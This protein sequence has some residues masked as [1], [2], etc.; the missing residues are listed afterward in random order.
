MKKPHPLLRELPLCL[1]LLAL[2]GVLYFEL[3]Q[4]LTF[5]ALKQH[6]EFLLHWSHHH[7]ITAGLIFVLIYIAS[8]AISMPVAVFLN[9]ISGYLFGLFWGT[10]CA[11]L[12][13]GI[14]AILLFLA[15]NTALGDW[16]ERRASGW[17]KTLEQGFQRNA[18]NYLLALRLIPIVP[19]WVINIVA[20]LVNVRL[21][22]FIMATFM[23]IIPETFLYVWM[24]NGL[25]HMFKSGQMLSLSM[26]LA[27]SS[28]IPLLVLGLLP[29]IP[30]IYKR[31]KNKGED[32]DSK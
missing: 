2:V 17:V 7:P 27:P 32:D 18:F 22:T 19:F 12:G 25:E 21:E 11:V 13:A 30:L 29:V 23:G 1:V 8:V 10:V 14:G 9:V 15:V 5:E 6:R 31:F 4:Y 3:H 16:L 26:L 28:L 24:G 20:A